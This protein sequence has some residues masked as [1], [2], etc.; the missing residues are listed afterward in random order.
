MEE[1]NK[2][3]RMTMVKKKWAGFVVLNGPFP[4]VCD[5]QIRYNTYLE[6][7]RD[8]A[9]WRSVLCRPIQG[10]YLDTAWRGGDKSHPERTSDCNKETHSLLVVT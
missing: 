7:T 10:L 5:V 4:T 9:K 6:L 3:K 1:N 8:F 2:N